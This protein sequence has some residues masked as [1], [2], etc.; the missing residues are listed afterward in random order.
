MKPGGLA[1]FAA[2]M[3]LSTAAAA[4]SGVVGHDCAAFGDQDGVDAKPAVARVRAG[5]P[6]Y[7]EFRQRASRT[8]VPGHL[9]LAFGRLD[10]KGRPATRRFA[11]LEPGNLRPGP[12]VNGGRGISPSV[13]DCTAP[14][15][16][17][18][19]VSLSA[20]QYARLTARIREAA[21]SPQRWRVFAFNCH[22]FV[23]WV[24]E[25]VG[26][27][28]GG[29]TAVPSALYIRAFIAANEP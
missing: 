18:Y 13:R 17:A 2:V 10:G 4:G 5:D 6:Y 15:Q 28:S 20:R 19:R 1:L 9:Y 29:V 7:V 14:V 23:A 24:G 3:M 22:D 12:A 16:V 11:G 21:A 26:M 27:K 25:A 8:I